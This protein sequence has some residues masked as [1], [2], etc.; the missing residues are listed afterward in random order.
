MKP[1]AND[2]SVGGS[3]EEV[4]DDVMED[5][6]VGD[7]VVEDVDVELF[8]NMVAQLINSRGRGAGSS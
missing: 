3:G 7:D 4:G 6:E 8:L 2:S 1:T 5:V